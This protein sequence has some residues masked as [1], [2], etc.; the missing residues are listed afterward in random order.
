MPATL[1]A[2]SAAHRRKSGGK[3]GRILRLRWLRSDKL[4]ASPIFTY[5]RPPAAPATT[6]T[7][8]DCVPGADRNVPSGQHHRNRHHGAAL[9]QAVASDPVLLRGL[10]AQLSAGRAVVL[11]CN[12]DGSDVAW[13]GYLRCGGERRSAN[14]GSKRVPPLRRLTVC[15]LGILVRRAASAHRSSGGNSRVGAD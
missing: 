2:D 3:Y 12:G 5:R 6:V 4:G 13:P 14:R 9:K 8:A 1:L 15:G 10:E 11:D 7:Q